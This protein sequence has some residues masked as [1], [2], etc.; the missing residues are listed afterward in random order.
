MMEK[1]S[2]MRAARTV[3]MLA[4][5]VVFLMLTACGDLTL[6]G[7]AP[8]D[9]TLEGKI[10]Q[11]PRLGHVYCMRGFL[12]VFS[13]GMDELAKKIDTQLGVSAVSVAD[14]EHYR[15]QDFLVEK[16]QEGLLKEPLV[17]LGHSYGADDQIRVAY[18][19]Q[20][21][22][23]G[24]DLLVLIDPVTP[25]K[26]P[27]NV[28]RVYNIYRSRPLTDMYP[29]WRGVPVEVEDSAKTELVNIDLR[30]ANVDFNADVHHALI[31]KVPGI[32]DMAMKEIAKVCGLRQGVAAKK[33]ESPAASVQQTT[34]VKSAPV[35]NPTVVPGAGPAAAA[36]N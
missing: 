23:I 21:H 3:I 26:V 31:D 18:T 10:E 25:P 15:L 7:A 2:I 6:R 27:A 1:C 22:G 11:H 28:K 16:H 12:G 5:P 29:W 35:A 32:H 30:T 17:L 34:S 19:L 24:V 20:E 33:E 36:P 13:T 9:S 14:E 4:A 8:L